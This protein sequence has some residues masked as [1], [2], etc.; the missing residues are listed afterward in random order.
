LDF[1]VVDGLTEPFFLTS[2]LGPGKCNV[3]TRLPQWISPLQIGCHPVHPWHKSQ[4]KNL[5]ATRRRT[6]ID[7]NTSLHVVP[8][9]D[10]RRCPLRV[11][12]QIVYISGYKLNNPNYT[13]TTFKYVEGR[14]PGG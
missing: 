9:M 11:H 10:G 13:V 7:L 5:G 6:N 3:R 1:N 2:P 14:G 4:P 8:K 12:Y